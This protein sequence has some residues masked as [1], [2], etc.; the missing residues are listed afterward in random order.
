MAKEKPDVSVWMTAYFHENYI[1]QAIESVLSQ[2]TDYSYEIVIR[3]DCSKDGTWK[4]I[5]GY[6][7]KYPHLIRAVRNEKNLGL[8]ANVLATK[9]MCRGRYIVN[10]SGDDY[11]ICDNKIQM[12][13]DFLEENSDYIGVGT[14]VELR[15]DDLEVADSFYPAQKYLGKDYDKAMFEAGVALPSHGLMLRNIFADE[16][17][18]E[19]IEKAYSVSSSIDDIFDPYLFLNFGKLFIM[20]DAT[21]A[22]RLVSDKSG[23]QNFNSTMETY[24]KAEVLMDGFVRFHE[25]FGDEVNLERRFTS[26]MNLAI[27][28]ATRSMKFSGVKELYKKIPEQYRKPWYRSIAVRSART[29]FSSGLAYTKNAMKA[30]RALSKKK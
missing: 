27:L 12:Q 14:K 23:K 30:K 1:A 17:K 4:V 22:H 7:D 11:W 20:E 19:L 24:R 9:K 13:A 26:V 6:A 25:I 15:Y 2:K 21:S 29:L 16:E 5:E 28:S 10:L 18:S 8:S 3:D